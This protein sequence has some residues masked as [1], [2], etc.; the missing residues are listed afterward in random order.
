[1]YIL[2]FPQSVPITQQLVTEV[3]MLWFVEV[4]YPCVNLL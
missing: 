1:M 3:A 2:D 4:I